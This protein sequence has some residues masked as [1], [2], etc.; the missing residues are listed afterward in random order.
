MK[1]ICLNIDECGNSE[2]IEEGSLTQPT[3]FRCKLCCSIALPYTDD[4]KPIVAETEEEFEDK[5]KELIAALHNLIQIPK[6]E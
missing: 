3:D 2:P 4:Y 5:S 1:L 6:G